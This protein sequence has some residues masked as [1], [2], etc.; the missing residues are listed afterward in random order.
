MSDPFYH[1]ENR[2]RR[3]AEDLQIMA[4][5]AGLQW[6]KFATGLAALALIAAIFLTWRFG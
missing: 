4:K 3:M 2:H 5:V 1:D 6:A